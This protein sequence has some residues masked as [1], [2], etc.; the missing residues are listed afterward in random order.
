MLMGLCTISVDIC[1]YLCLQRLENTHDACLL[2]DKPC[3]VL[4][5][6]LVVTRNNNNN[7]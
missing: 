7:K 6:M 5:T 1:G 3:S 4:P 2:T